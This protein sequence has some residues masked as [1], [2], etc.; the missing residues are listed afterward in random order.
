MDNVVIVTIYLKHNTEHSVITN[1]RGLC[2]NKIFMVTY[3]DHMHKL[4]SA[5]INTK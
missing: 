2:S 4:P 5:K 1:Y 3:N